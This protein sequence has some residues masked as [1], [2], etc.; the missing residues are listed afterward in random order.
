MHGQLLGAFG[1]ALSNVY[2]KSTLSSNV[3]NAD[4][5]TRAPPR[6]SIVVLN[7]LPRASTPDVAAGCSPRAD[8]GSPSQALGVGEDR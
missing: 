7:F 4:R 3:C 5:Q 6:Y 8:S 1:A 2:A